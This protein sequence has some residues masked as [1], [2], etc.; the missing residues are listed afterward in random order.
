[1]RQS[2]VLARPSFLIIA[3]EAC[4][5]NNHLTINKMDARYEICCQKIAMI[6]TSTTRRR[7][8]AL[9]VVW[10]RPQQIAH[11]TLV[12]VRRVGIRTW[13]HIWF[14]KL[15]IGLKL[16]VAVPYLVWDFLEAVHGPNAIECL[17]SWRQTTVEAK[18]LYN[19]PSEIVQWRNRSG[20]TRKVR[21]THTRGKYGRFEHKK[22][23]CIIGLHE[24]T[25]ATTNNTIHSISRLIS[26]SPIEQPAAIYLHWPD[27]RR[28]RSEG[29]S[30]RG[31]WSRS[32]RPR[33][34]T[35]GDTH[36]RSHTPIDK[37]W[38]E[39]ENNQDMDKEGC[40][41]SCLGWLY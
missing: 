21:L 27:F 3:K 29:G 36:H 40:I 17:D 13:L 16:F 9:A 39:R 8:P 7:V 15:H 6:H 23:R 22:K 26:A 33:W 20:L 32:T 30:R 1:M 38:N 41:S 34:H 37:E 5:R 2:L 28:G 19:S 31:R 25:F 18:D 35:C 12:V 11:R 24:N 4:L 10:V 14:V